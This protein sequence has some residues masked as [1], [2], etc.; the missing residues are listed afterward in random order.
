MPRHSHTEFIGF[1]ETIH[2]SVS[3]RKQVHLILDNYGTHKHPKVKEWLA[4]HPRYHLHFTPTGSSWLNMVERFFSELTTRRIRRGTFR[5][6]PE[7]ERAIRCY[8][9]EHN[10]NPTPFV[11][12][13]T[14]GK[15]V[16]KIKHCKELLETGH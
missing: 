13:A 11:W 1:L 6:V 4:A 2:R 10:K 15:I 8:L 9:R 5:S 3:R 14:A 7:L 12:T 16:R